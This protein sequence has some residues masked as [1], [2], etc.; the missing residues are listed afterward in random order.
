M[1]WNTSLSGV[2]GPNV[3]ILMGGRNPSQRSTQGEKKRVLSNPN[4]LYY[5]KQIAST[6]NSCVFSAVKGAPSVSPWLHSPLFSRQLVLQAHRFSTR[7]KHSTPS[8]SSFLYFW[9]LGIL[10]L[11]CSMPTDSQARL[12]SIC[13]ILGSPGSGSFIYHQSQLVGMEEARS[14]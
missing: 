10:L 4:S 6:P 5:H 8:R 7:S 13:I 2:T 3:E 9:P 11:H 12:P 1:Q 14:S